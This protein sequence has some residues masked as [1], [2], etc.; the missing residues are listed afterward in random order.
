M[1]QRLFLREGA[2]AGFVSSNQPVQ[3][4]I[5]GADHNHLARVMRARPGDTLVLL[6]N[7]GGAFQAKIET[8]GKSTTLV[9]VLAQAD[10][11]AFAPE[12]IVTIVVAQALGKGDKLEQ[13]IQHGA[14]AGA[15]AFAPIVAERCVVEFPA[16]GSPRAMEKLAR[17]NAIAKGA[18][19]QSCLL[20]V[21]AVEEPV[22]AAELFTRAE[23]GDTLRLLLQPELTGVTVPLHKALS[24]GTGAETVRPTKIKIVIAVG[25]EG[26]WSPREQAIGAQAGWTAVSL[27][28]RVLRTE[29]AALVA[30]SQIIYHFESLTLMAACPSGQPIK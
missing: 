12:P 21:P 19:E 1:A 14:E 18:A 25:P 3:V 11:G 24:I 10:L 2:L 5:D 28:P 26:G 13:V 15:S 23:S 27:G 8:I 16:P 20:K 6:D 7:N 22:K 17:W 9:S 4:E 30:I 29:T